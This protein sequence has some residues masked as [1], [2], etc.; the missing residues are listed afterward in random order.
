MT[1]DY[2][3]LIFFLHLASRSPILL[4]LP[5]HW[6]SYVCRLLLSQ[7]LNVKSTTEL[8]SWPYSLS[9][10]TSSQGSFY[11]KPYP[12]AVNNIYR[13]KNFQIFISS[14]TSPE[15][16][17]HTSSCLHTIS[18]WKSKKL[19]NGVSPNRTQSSPS[20]FPS[21]TFLVSVTV[22]AIQLGW[23]SRNHPWCFFLAQTLHPSI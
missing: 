14:F 13:L 20:T 6:Y 21:V 7:P 9:S 18:T 22:N 17:M 10:H 1:V 19:V 8:S 3:S 16:Q 15:H 11:P 12:T 4:F 23:T 5:P 2:F